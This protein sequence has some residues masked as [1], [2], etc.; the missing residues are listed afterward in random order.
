[1]TNI[2]P[3][4]R[5]VVPFP[6]ACGNCWYCQQGMWAL[7]DNSNPNSLMLEKL[8]GDTGAG[9]FGYSHLYGGYAGGQAEYVRVPFADVGPEKIPESLSDDQVIF[10]TDIFPTAYQ[11]AENCAIRNG[12]T[13]AIWGCGPVGLLAIKCAQHLGAGKV[14]AIDRVPERLNMAR[15]VC[16][17][18]TLNY[19]DGE[20]TR[21]LHEMTGGRGP[22]A[23]IDAVGMEAD[24]TG[25]EAAYDHLKQSLRLE[26]DRPMALR[27]LIMA[28]RKGGTI[29]IAGVYSGY[30]DKMP[31]GALFGKGLTLRGG[32][33]HVQKYLRPLMQLIESGTLDT[34]FLISH[35]MV[36]DEAPQAYDM[37]CTK[38]NQCIK[39]VMRTDG[40]AG[41][42]KITPGPA[43][44]HTVFH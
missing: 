13:I 6:I 7:C 25:F 29:S 39:V 44:M 31:M 1:V 3:G 36:L 10:L 27:E 41:A 38:Q 22:D 11:A 16:G 35:R 8:Y 34:R 12:D 33:T 5:V 43:S 19:E 40:A 4:D 2:K 17:A 30:I 42:R 14:I 23:C 24:G 37:F 26:Q 15:N 20:I 18:E 9:I 21:R 32:Q 28:C